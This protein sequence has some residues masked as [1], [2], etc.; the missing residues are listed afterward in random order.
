MDDFN[1]FILA[2]R[3][4]D[5]VQAN[6][7]INKVN[8]NQKDN[9]CYNGLQYAC[10][11]GHIDIVELLIENN[12]DINYNNGD[13][14][15]DEN[16]TGL[17]YATINKHKNIVELLLNNGANIYSIDCYGHNAFFYACENNSLDIVKLL[18]SFG[19]DI[20]S[21]VESY[22]KYN[23]FI[24]ACENGNHEIVKY[25]IE[26]GININY[27]TLCGYSGFE[28]ACF[29]DNNLETV[30]ILL[31]NDININDL[32]LGFKYACKHKSINVI[33]LIISFGIIYNEY[34]DFIKPYLGIINEYINTK[35]YWIN[36]YNFNK[37]FSDIFSLIVL[38]SDDYLKFRIL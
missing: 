38:I 22:Y 15:I 37:S 12:I 3:E 32:Y 23:G 14:L 2:C 31:N 28:S 1:N 5:V 16:R 17:I 35:E 20:N 11:N 9:F 8:I 29:N 6:L 10:E 4:N 18:I 36:R 21:E 13:D 7:L 27:K 26:N 24:M 33:K 30:K 25:L 19:F 34:D